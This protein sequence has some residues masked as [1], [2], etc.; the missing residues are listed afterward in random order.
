MHYLFPPAFLLI[1]PLCCCMVYIPGYRR[2]ARARAE[3]RA[4]QVEFFREYWNQGESADIPPCC[5]MACCPGCRPRARARAEARA[6]QDRNI[7]Y[8][9][10]SAYIGAPNEICVTGVVIATKAPSDELSFV[11]PE[12]AARNETAVVEPVTVAIATAVVNRDPL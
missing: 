7:V 10:E 5:C 6:E 11:S 8:L 2:R 3:A 12:A 4:E 1:I 9:R